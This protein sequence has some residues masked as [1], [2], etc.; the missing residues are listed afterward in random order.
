MLIKRLAKVIAK[1][2]EALELAQLRAKKPEQD[3]LMLKLQ[4]PLQC[5]DILRLLHGGHFDYVDNAMTFE[6]ILTV[7][8]PQVPQ[9]PQVPFPL[10]RMS[11]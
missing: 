6:N 2:R 1:K 4:L 8:V 3:F 10:G 9:I 7:L 11:L 5:F